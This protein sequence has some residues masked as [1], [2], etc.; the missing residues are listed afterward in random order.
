[1][2]FSDSSIP[3]V[4]SSVGFVLDSAEVALLAPLTAANREAADAGKDPLER[5]LMWRATDSMGS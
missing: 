2:P 1:M 5:C 4:W 3:V